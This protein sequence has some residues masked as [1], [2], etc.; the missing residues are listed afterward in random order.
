MGVSQAD[1]RVLAFGDQHEQG[2]YY[3]GDQNSHHL[4]GTSQRRKRFQK[5]LVCFRGD[6][7][8]KKVASRSVNCSRCLV[9]WG[10]MRVT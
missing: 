2:P 10:I 4:E 5:P 1:P 9:F 6:T 8:F 7:A 3:R